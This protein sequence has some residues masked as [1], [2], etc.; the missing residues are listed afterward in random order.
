LGDKIQVKLI[1]VDEE[2]AEL[3]F[4]ILDIRNEI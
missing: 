4:I 3:D 1:R 2:R